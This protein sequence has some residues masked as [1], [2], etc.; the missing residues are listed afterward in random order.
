R[1][2]KT[3]QRRQPATVPADVARDPTGAETVFLKHNV[4]SPCASQSLRSA[5]EACFIPTSGS[6]LLTSC[7]G[8]CPNSDS[9]LPTSTPRCVCKHQGLYKHLGAKMFRNEHRAKH[10][11]RLGRSRNTA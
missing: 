4:E 1:H 2:R 5:N 11:R 9:R 7:L 6:R 3:H 10:A 8:R